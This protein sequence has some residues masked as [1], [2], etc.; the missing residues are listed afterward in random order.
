[1]I[2]YEKKYLIL[3]NGN[4]NELIIREF[5]ELDERDVY[6]LACEET[7]DGE[8]IKSA[9]TRGKEAL[10]CSWQSTNILL[11]CSS[12]SLESRH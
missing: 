8:I 3:K 11:N 5:L 12:E 9:I 2:N 4:T 6:S 7:Y 1:M 10:L